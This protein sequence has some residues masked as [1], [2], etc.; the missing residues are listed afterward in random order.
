MALNKT[1]IKKIQVKTEKEPDIRNFL[2]NLLEFESE[3]QGWYT[4]KY[5]DILEKTCKEEK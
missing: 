5:A 3:P 2:I 1:I 4:Q